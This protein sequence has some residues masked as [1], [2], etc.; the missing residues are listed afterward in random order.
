MKFS[1]KDEHAGQEER[2]NALRLCEHCD[3]LGASAMISADRESN[4][5]ICCAIC[6]VR[7][8]F[9][10]EGNRILV[11]KVEPVEH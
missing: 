1:S 7:F 3:L 10:T 11:T 6:K 9:L 8:H 2:R 5:V 4:E